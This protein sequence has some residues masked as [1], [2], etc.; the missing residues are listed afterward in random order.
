[1]ADEESPSDPGPV[2]P[3]DPPPAQDVA[4]TQDAVP[5]DAPLPDF[6]F[7][8]SLRGGEPYHETKTM[9]EQSE[10]PRD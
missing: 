6:H 9:I 3:A 7:E 1:M 8:P 2:A 5:V 4:P 10:D